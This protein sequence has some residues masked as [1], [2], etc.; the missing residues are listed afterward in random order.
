LVPVDKRIIFCSVCVPA[1]AYYHTPIV[2]MI[3]KTI[4]DHLTLTQPDGSVKELGNQKAQDNKKM[5][6]PEC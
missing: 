1:Y 4:A 6:I 2:V 3:N 5:H